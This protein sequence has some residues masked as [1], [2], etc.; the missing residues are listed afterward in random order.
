ML[1]TSLGRENLEL[2]LR[3]APKVFADPCFRLAGGKQI[4]LVRLSFRV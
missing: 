1:T 4:A 3:V 2:F